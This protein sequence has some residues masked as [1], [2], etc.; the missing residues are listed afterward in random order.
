MSLTEGRGVKVTRGL[1]RKAS[2]LRESLFPSVRPWRHPAQLSL[3]GNL[4]WEHS[5]LIA[6]TGLCTFGHTWYLFPVR[7]LR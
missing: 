4:F 2:A 5:S 1:G 7:L 3:G 6:S